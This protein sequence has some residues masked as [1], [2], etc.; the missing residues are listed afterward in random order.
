MAPLL[1]VPVRR[2][3][4]LGESVREPGVRLRQALPAAQ[5]LRRSPPQ[6]GKERGGVL[7]RS[8]LGGGGPAYLDAGGVLSA[9]LGRGGRSSS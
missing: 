4:D 5:R 8:R 9:R 1:Q 3:V 7:R 6:R 2:S